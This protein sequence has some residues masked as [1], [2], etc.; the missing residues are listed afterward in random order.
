MYLIKPNMKYFSSI[1]AMVLAVTM[2][3]FLTS[4]NSSGGTTTLPGAWDK[5]GSFEGIPRSGAVSFVIGNYAYV[6]TGFNAESN[7]KL[8]D[9]WK[10]DATADTWTPMADLPAS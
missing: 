10:Y 6:G 7:T 1:A 2:Q 5:M 9:F 4:C 8:K 3:F